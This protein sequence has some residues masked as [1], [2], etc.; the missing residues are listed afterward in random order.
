MHKS[1]RDGILKRFYPATVRAPQTRNRT[2]EELEQEI[3][4]AIE[5]RPG[6]TQRELVERLV[7][8]DKV[9][10]NHLRKLVRESKIAS[11]KNG[12]TRMYFPPGKK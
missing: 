12:K 4:K 10:G 2:P 6:T 5:E 9:V 11:Q 7:V 8:S 3:I 1:Q